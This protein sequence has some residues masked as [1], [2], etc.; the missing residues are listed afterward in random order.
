M[1]KRMIVV[2]FLCT[3]PLLAWGDGKKY[4]EVEGRVLNVASGCLL[5]MSIEHEAV[6]VRLA[7]I[8]CL[9]EEDPHLK[10]VKAF[11]RSIVMNQVVRV[12]CMGKGRAGRIIGRLYVED[13]C[14]NDALVVPGW[15]LR[16]ES[17]G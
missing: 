13:R 9:K 11:M 16:S 4:P 6:I 1:L 8:D 7:G 15:R 3:L 2:F 14:L 5:V 17:P 10:E 12:E